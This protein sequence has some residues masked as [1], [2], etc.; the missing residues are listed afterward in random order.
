MTDYETVRVYTDG[1]CPSNPSKIG[2]IGIFNQTTGTGLGYRVEDEDTRSYKGTGLG[3]YLVSEIV[4]MH[5]A[6]IYCKNN[7]PKGSIFTIQF[8]LDNGFIHAV[9][10]SITNFFILFFDIFRFFIFII[11][12]NQLKYYKIGKKI[13]GLMGF[14][15]ATFNYKNKQYKKIFGN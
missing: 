14:I 8:K 9:F 15:T 7:N 6:K 1:S 5:G 11:L 2:G 12:L 3:L 4:K 10:K 13:M